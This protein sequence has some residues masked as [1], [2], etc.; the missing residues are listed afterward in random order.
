[1]TKH[2]G[3]SLIGALLFLVVTMLVL[4][5]WDTGVHEGLLDAISE[6]TVYRATLKAAFWIG[7]L[8]GGISSIALRKSENRKTYIWIVLIFL[9][10]FTEFV[11]VSII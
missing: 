8:A 5:F 2:L 6:S 1:M 3:Y 4:D 9:L 10:M 11:I 7:A